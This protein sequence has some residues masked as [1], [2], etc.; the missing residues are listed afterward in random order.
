MSRR[1]L[2]V[3]ACV[4]VVASGPLNAQG[5]TVC[6]RLAP[7]LE[8]H[9]KTARIK[10]VGEVPEWRRDLV[11]GLKGALVG[12][13]ANAMF[14]LEGLDNTVSSADLSKQC[15]GTKKGVTCN[16]K[17][18]V[19]FNIQSG[20]HDASVDLEEGENAV[21]EMRKTKLVCRDVA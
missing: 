18:P 7:Q 10:G 6:Q 1:F 5:E 16:L 8:L 11:G 15:E 14:S 9:E 4:A 3:A 13:S 19:R 20:E 2:A 21:F 17:G 12:G